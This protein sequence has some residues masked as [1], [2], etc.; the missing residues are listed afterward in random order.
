MYYSHG[1]NAKR[2]VAFLKIGDNQ[3]VRIQH[4]V[5]HPY[6]TFTRFTL[7]GKHL[8][9]PGFNGQFFKVIYRIADGAFID[10]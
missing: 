1:R 4:D 10:S 3:Q 2:S 9:Y 7:A 5:S 6:P 8:Q